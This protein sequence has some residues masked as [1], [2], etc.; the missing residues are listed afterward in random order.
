MPCF[1]GAGH[2]YVW[3]SFGDTHTSIPVYP[4][5]S[6]RAGRFVGRLQTE[7]GIH[8]R[9][10]EKGAPHGGKLIDLTVASAKDSP[11]HRC[12]HK[13]VLNERQMCDFELL[14]VG[15]FSPLTGFMVCGLL[16]QTTPP[17]R[18][19][20]RLVFCTCIWPYLTMY[21]IP[22]RSFLYVEDAY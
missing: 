19:H 21:Y 9:I 17:R 3:K 18:F 20:T 4:N 12:T 13:I 7:C 16:F 15:G 14:A 6:E 22:V 1:N 8:T 5:E 10:A 2:V 11:L